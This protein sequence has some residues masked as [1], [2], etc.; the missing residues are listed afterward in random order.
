MI[1]ARGPAKEAGF[2]I[3]EVLV[4]ATLLL[5]GMLGVVTM[6]NGANSAVSSAR[7]REAATNLAREIAE[8]ARSIPYSQVDAATL[9]PRLQ[10]MDGLASTT[11]APTWTIPRRGTTFRVDASV[12]S[13]DDTRD[14]LG[15]HSDG[16]YCETSTSTTDPSPRDLK[17][18]TIDVGWEDRGVQRSVRQVAVVSP[19][20]GKD[21]PL[22]TSLTA[23]SPTFPDPSHPLVTSSAT[24]Q[25]TFTVV[26]SATADRVIWSLDGVDQTPAA[27]AAAAPKTWTFT[28]PISALSDGTYSVG[29]RA[30]DANDVE[31]TTHEIPLDLLRGVPGAPN[32][33]GSGYNT[34]REGGGEVQA[35][36]VEWL[37]NP[38][39]NV[40]GYRVYRS[41]GSL[42]CPGSASTLDE[43]L[44]C[45]DTAPLTGDYEVVAV[46]RAVDGS[47]GEGLRASTTPETGVTTVPPSLRRLWLTPVTASTTNCPDAGTAGREMTT[48]YTFPATATSLLLNN[49]VPRFCSPTATETETYPASSAPTPTTT[50]SV[51][52]RN[53]SNG[54][55]HDCTISAV[56]GLNGGPGTAAQQTHTIQNKTDTAVQRTFTFVHGAFGLPTGSR[57]VIDVAGTGGC[58]STY[59]EFASA[60]RP[61]YFEYLQPERT[62]STPQPQTPTGLTITATTAGP[63]LTWTA[64]TTGAVIESYRIYRGGTDHTD[65]YDR[66]GD[67]VPEYTDP[68]PRP[69]LEYWVTSVGPD[70][71]ESPPAGP[72]TT[73]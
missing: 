50:A 43:R 27:V 32:V 49:A 60:S 54:A 59:L 42:A 38:E 46:F 71:V 67:A 61:S 40:E 3:I 9:S 45:V 58:G 48:P 15:D 47:I 19:G 23:T 37:A 17:R 68:K 21:A 44:T 1:L 62:T 33:T 39:R 51:W 12:C 35:V 25:V 56:A 11:T 20:N 24:T 7:E 5:V 13:V 16:G 4:A 65:R 52:V 18:I 63:K 8:Q 31:G 30:V 6:V 69:G 2:T 41:D 70:L 64:P 26:G 73:P 36:E 66:T 57:L 22:I 34:V 28:L 29:A 10:A 14:G 55:S 72:V 53:T